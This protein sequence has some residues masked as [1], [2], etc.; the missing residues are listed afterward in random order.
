MLYIANYCFASM[1]NRTKIIIKKEWKQFKREG[2]LKFILLG[3]I[4]A[5]SMQIIYILNDIQTSKMIGAVMSM[6]L[7]FGISQV[8][9]PASIAR[10]KE[11]GTLEVLLTEATSQ[12][13]FWG[14][15]LFISA[16]PSAI[17]SVAFLI[18]LMIM[19]FSG[20]FVMSIIL[21]LSIY[22]FILT[23]SILGII[24][25]AKSRSFNHALQI[26][27]Q[28]SG[29]AAIPILGIMVIF[30]YNSYFLAVPLLLQILLFVTIYKLGIS[31]FADLDK[32]VYS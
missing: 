5:F 31:R 18:S 15:F 26:T 22:L 9:A 32:L 12:E 30:T 11:S 16:I 3:V 7:S 21:Y 19:F 13:V 27:H 1:N 14:K 23:S 4:L 6:L 29:V 20:I 8:L 28:I 2:T 10:E 17:T 25:S 24:A